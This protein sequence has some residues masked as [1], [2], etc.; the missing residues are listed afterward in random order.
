MSLWNGTVR[1]RTTT[2]EF[3]TDSF[4]NLLFSICRFREVTGIYPKKI[5]VVS[6]TFKQYRFQ[7][8]HA[9]SIIWPPDQFEYIG[10][11]PEESTG[12]NLAAATDGERKNA[13]VPFETD[14]YGCHSDTL[15]KKR[16][17]RNPFMRTPPYELTCSEMKNILT[18]CGP[19]IYNMEDLPWQKI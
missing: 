2:E 14:P 4:Q 9:S 11:D 6:Y 7:E 17:Q 10:V 19:K 16:M 13:A 8:M 5:S 18:W 12:F 15:V 1:A 3:A